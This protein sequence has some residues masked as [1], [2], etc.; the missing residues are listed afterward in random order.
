MK[1]TTS[2]FIHAFFAASLLF[3]ITASAQGSIRSGGQDLNL[4]N[5]PPPGSPSGS[6]ALAADYREQM[7]ALIIKI[8]RFTRRVNKDFIVM[9][10]GGL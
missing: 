4:T 7:R 5:D 9:T 2:F 6:S 3:P 8:S 10:R 1:A